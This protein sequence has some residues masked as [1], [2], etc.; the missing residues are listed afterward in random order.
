MAKLPEPV[1]I[2][3]R[4]EKDGWISLKRFAEIIGVSYPT[5]CAMRDRGEIHPILVGG[6]YRVYKDE[7][8]RFKQEWKPEQGHTKIGKIMRNKI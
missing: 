7:Y 2:P 6:I 8:V 4:M 3:P 1:V 5:A